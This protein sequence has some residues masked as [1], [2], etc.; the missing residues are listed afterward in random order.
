[1]LVSEHSPKRADYADAVRLLHENTP[2]AAHLGTALESVHPGKVTI[3]LE[4]ERHLTQQHGYA[5]AGLLAT[6]A[7]MA[8]GL[9]AYS[10]MERYSLC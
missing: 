9:A 8:C 10:L 6:L 2:L 4:L 7:D 1:M 3:S 5:H